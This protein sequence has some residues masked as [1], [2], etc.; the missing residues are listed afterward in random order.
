MDG[1]GDED[2]FDL[3]FGDTTLPLEDG[4]ES[5]KDSPKAT[6]KAQMTDDLQLSSD[7]SLNFEEIKN[8]EEFVQNQAMYL[9]WEGGKI[10]LDPNKSELTIGKKIENDIVVKSSKTSKFHCKIENGKVLVDCN[11]KNGTKLNGKR[12]EKAELKIGDLIEVGALTF[13]ISASSEGVI[14]HYPADG[15]GHGERGS[16]YEANS[17]NQGH[18]GEKQD[19][20]CKAGKDSFKKKELHE[21]KH[22]L[23]TNETNGADEKE[24]NVDLEDKKNSFS[25][26]D[27]FCEAL[28]VNLGLDD[29]KIENLEEKRVN[30]ESEIQNAPVETSRSIE[31]TKSVQE[32]DGN[33]L[34]A[35]DSSEKPRKSEEDIES[36][37]KYS[38]QKNTA[39]KIEQSNNEISEEYEKTKVKTVPEINF[40]KV[41]TKQANDGTSEHSEPRNAETEKRPEPCGNDN[42]MGKSLTEDTK[43]TLQ[44]HQEENQGKGTKLSQALDETLNNNDVF[45]D[46]ELDDILDGETSALLQRLDSHITQQSKTLKK[47]GETADA[48]ERRKS[49]PMEDIN[50]SRL[51]QEMLREQ[52]EI[53]YEDFDHDSLDKGNLQDPSSLEKLDDEQTRE[54]LAPPKDETS[55]KSGVLSKRIIS[56][57]EV[58]VG[59][60]AHITHSPEGQFEEPYK[61]SKLMTVEEKPAT[62]VGQHAQSTIR[63][64]K[65]SQKR[66]SKIS[67]LKEQKVRKQDRVHT[68][69]KIEAL[70]IELNE[71]KKRN[72]KI[73]ARME[74]IRGEITKNGRGDI[75]RKLQ[76]VKKSNRALHEEN[77]RRKAKI[78]AALGR[79]K[80]IPRI[81]PHKFKSGEEK[82][83]IESYRME[84]KVGKKNYIAAADK[85]ESSQRTAKIYLEKVENVITRAKRASTE[86]CVQRDNVCKAAQ[87]EILVNKKQEVKLTRLLQ[88]RT[89]TH[90]LQS[91][92]FLLK[93]YVD[94]KRG[95]ITETHDLNVQLSAQ[96]KALDS[97]MQAIRKERESYTLRANKERKLAKRKLV[98]LDRAKETLQRAQSMKEIGTPLTMNMVRR[99]YSPVSSSDFIRVEYSSHGSEQT[100]Q[101]FISDKLSWS[102][103][104]V[105]INLEAC[106]DILEK[107]ETG[108]RVQL[109]ECA[110][111]L[112]FVNSTLRGQLEVVQ[113]P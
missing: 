2:D 105:E 61:R 3:D 54:T 82:K 32:T 11:S 58:N 113:E 31:D 27:S 38:S 97:Q 77:T 109:K 70:R 73:R 51:E 95:K 59:E 90:E 99:S 80:E 29:L 87:T 37:I 18:S 15:V 28:D 40:E 33:H 43:K 85:L 103:K 71:L 93:S 14:G 20:Q 56:K 100:L 5:R 64:I 4:F 48:I 12:V 88:K 94:E 39:T 75:I 96:M 67:G 21:E 111:R 7:S 36:K 26:T 1:S 69:I 46:F 42:K 104:L 52:K 60:R 91:R 57:E 112:E 66:L 16:S 92:Y 72:K 108:M 78:N 98:T 25:V 55:L 10:L 65:G 63:S 86:A 49:G 44:S 45:D 79:L 53:Q 83:I 41:I 9:S 106:R 30:N 68:Q 102:Q 17:P 22:N 107:V 23:S 47:A 76:K 81:Y 35:I 101:H 74:D 110:K 6:T 50:T 89:K 24:A 13:E 84:I 19:S 62:E 8:N 34:T